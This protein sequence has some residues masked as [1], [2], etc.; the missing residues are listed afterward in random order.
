M[1][2]AIKTGIRQILAAV[3]VFGIL[4]TLLAKVSSCMQIDL[5]Q[6]VFS[7]ADNSV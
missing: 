2:I 5:F 3:R 7:V 4:N 6:A 1:I